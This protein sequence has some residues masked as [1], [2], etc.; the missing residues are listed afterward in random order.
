MN[1]PASCAMI[2]QKK[3]ELMAGTAMYEHKRKVTDKQNKY[4]E[5]DNRKVI[6][7]RSIP[8]GLLIGCLVLFLIFMGE[9]DLSLALFAAA[10][11]VP[12][13][14][15]GVLCVLLIAALYVFASV[16]ILERKY[17]NIRGSYV[18][19]RLCRSELSKLNDEEQ[20]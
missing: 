6:V 10:G 2:N 12:V 3:V 4:F 1:A 13:I 5:E 18:K 11:A 19:Y 9:Y 17:E 15:L 8:A 16:F 7:L 14:I 20:M